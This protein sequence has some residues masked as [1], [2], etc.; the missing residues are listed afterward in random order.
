MQRNSYEVLVEQLGFSGSKRLVAVMEYMMNPEQ[1]A[2]AEALPGSPAEV[3]RKTSFGIKTVEAGLEELF[4]KGAIFPKGDM[5]KRESYRFARHIIQ[6]HD[7]VLATARLDPLGKD[8]RFF[9]LWHDFCL[10]EMYPFLVRFAEMLEHAPARVIPAYEA[11]KDLPDVQPW[12]NFREILKAQ[13]LIALVPCSCRLRTVAVEE[14]CEY[15]DEVKEWKCL[16]FGR[17]AEYVIARGSGKKI[18]LEETLELADKMEDQG[19]VH[20][21]GHDNNMFFNTSCQCC[22][23][24]CEVFVAMQQNDGNMVKFYDRSRYGAYLKAEDCS[25]CQNCL[26]RC[27]FE[28]IDLVRSGKKYKASIDLD[29]CWGCGVCVLKCETGTLKLKAIQPVDFIPKKSESR[30]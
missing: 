20:I 8:K 15:T 29:K 2:M 3:A 26:E 18:T 23:D 21:G 9:E 11:I 27:P 12:E 1:A 5:V 16:Q 19:L 24:C 14:P 10:Q 30:S 25:G 22:Q 17:A 4:L 28:A 6:F 7:A 13:E